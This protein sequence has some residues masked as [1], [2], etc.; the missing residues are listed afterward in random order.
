MTF[1]IPGP[2]EE[3]EM[4]HFLETFFY[5]QEA[6]LVSEVTKLDREERSIEALFD[7]TAP[8]PVGSLQ[9]VSAEH[10]AHVS[11]AE[12]L[13]LTGS[14]GCMHAW[15]FHGC[16]WDEAWSGFGSR[17]HRADFKNLATIGPPLRLESH[18]TRTRVGKKWVVMRLEFRF[19]QGADKLVYYGDQSAMFF[20]GMIIPGT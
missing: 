8:L 14:L 9:R 18:E 1:T 12:M 7:T 5:R 11:V 10:P 20:K 2:F 4:T 19:W 6:F 13:M 17:I 15:F 3:S 16:R